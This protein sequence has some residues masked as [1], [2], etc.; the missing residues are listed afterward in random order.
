M[1]L[2]KPTKKESILEY[3]AKT[4]CLV[5]TP[6]NVFDDG[7]DPNLFLTNGRKRTLSKGIRGII[8]GSS[9]YKIFLLQKS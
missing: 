7:E 3:S 6:K 2:Q 8:F 1:G 9:N 4:S 5:I